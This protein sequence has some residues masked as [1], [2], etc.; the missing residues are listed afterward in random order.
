[1]NLEPDLTQLA[2]KTWSS[3]HID[4]LRQTLQYIRRP[5]NKAESAVSVHTVWFSSGPKSA[6]LCVLNIVD[7]ETSVQT[8]GGD[9]SFLKERERA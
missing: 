4:R 8:P 6:S 1:M 5:K 9:S 2:T 7:N 3:H